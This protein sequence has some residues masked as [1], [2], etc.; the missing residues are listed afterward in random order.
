MN[1]FMDFAGCASPLAFFAMIFATIVLLRWFKHR[2]IMA[3]AEKGALPEQYA[4]YEKTARGRGLLI[5]GIVVAAVGL[6]LTLGLWPLGFWA[7]A[8]APLYLGP[9]LLGGLIP[10]FIGLALL[11]AYFVTRKEE[12]AASEAPSEEKKEEG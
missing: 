1:D 6:A 5:W 8:P 3:L 10:L 12:A 9:W 4:R 2:E 7:G 11:I